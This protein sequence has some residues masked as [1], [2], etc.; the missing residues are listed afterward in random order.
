M[1]HSLA[2]AMALP[3]ISVVGG[4]WGRSCTSLAPLPS[5]PP[6]EDPP[7]AQTTLLIH[8]CSGY[9]V[10][11][12]CAMFS[13][14]NDSDL[15]NTSPSSCQDMKHTSAHHAL[16]QLSMRGLLL[17]SGFIAFACKS[18]SC[19]SCSPIAHTGAIPQLECE[20]RKREEVPGMS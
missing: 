1:Y 12:H 4:T 14:G 17:H 13:A 11:L 9:Q 3:H 7:A 16:Q 15:S 20:V 10:K 2:T 8:T 18:P 6:L 5:G 19:L